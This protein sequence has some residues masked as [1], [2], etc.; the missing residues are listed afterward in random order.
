LL[1]RSWEQRGQGLHQKFI[2]H[3]LP[4]C[5]RAWTGASPR[6]HPV[7]GRRDHAHDCKA[8]APGAA[9]RRIGVCPTPAA[10]TAQQ[11]K[12]ERK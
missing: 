11:A 7:S 2:A 10:A 12:V 5:L 9:V 4:I 3:V 1:A 8:K 6:A